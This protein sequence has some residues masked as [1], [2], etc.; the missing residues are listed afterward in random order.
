MVNVTKCPSCS[1]IKTCPQCG[2]PVQGFLLV[3]IR[4]TKGRIS[5]LHHWAQPCGHATE[6]LHLK[7]RVAAGKALATYGGG[8]LWQKGYVWVNVFWGSYW[9][10]T[11]ATSP[12]AMVTAVKNIGSNP[13][14]FGGLSEYHVGMGVVGQTFVIPEDPPSSIDDSQIQSQLQSWISNA[15]ITD[16]K[17]EGAYN[18]F[19]PPGV[20]VS[21][22]GSGSCSSFCDYHSAVSPM[23]PFYTVEPY[24]CSSGCNQCTSSN[25]DTLTQGL[26][27]EMVELA[28]DM[29]PGT[30]W[31]I[32]NEELCDH[33]DAS[34]V[35]RTI[36][37]GEYV[38][39]WYSN[40]LGRC[41]SD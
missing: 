41:W 14:Y 1:H 9:S 2:K 38:N 30:G 4:A 27:E 22:Q 37:S 7:P 29:N 6:D 39:S 21:L 34:F 18:I 10:K 5:K 11:P 33:C 31:V 16:V 25:F 32:G 35:C 20:T 26:S 40:A 15:T 17:A 3:G 19:F 8:P 36:S 28:T 23:G 24:P 12:D 13:S